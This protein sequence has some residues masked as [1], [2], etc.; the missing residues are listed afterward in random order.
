[1]QAMALRVLEKASKCIQ[2]CKTI[3]G[4]PAGLPRV[5]NPQHIGFQGT[6]LSIGKYE[7]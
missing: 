5:F 2:I 4:M 3:K 1:M 7:L 6:S